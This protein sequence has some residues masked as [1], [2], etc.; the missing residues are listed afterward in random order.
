MRSW[1]LKELGGQEGN[2]MKGDKMAGDHRATKDLIGSEIAK[3]IK[4]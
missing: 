4:S 3:T 2:K 1:D